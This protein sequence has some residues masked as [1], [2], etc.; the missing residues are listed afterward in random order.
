MGL[1]HAFLSFPWTVTSPVLV[2]KLMQNRSVPDK[3]QQN[4][5]W[6]AVHHITEDV[7]AQ[8]Y[9]TRNSGDKRPPKRRTGTRRTLMGRR[10][11]QTGTP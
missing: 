2:D 3:L 11:A 6:E 4:A 8:I 7:V 10:I 9:G 5:F 1:G